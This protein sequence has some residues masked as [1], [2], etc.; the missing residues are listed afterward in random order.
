MGRL[1]GHKKYDDIL[2]EIEA[3][4]GWVELEDE[5]LEAA[6]VDEELDTSKADEETGDEADFLE[7][8]FVEAEQSEDV[9]AVEEAAEPEDPL[10]SMVVDLLEEDARE[11]Q[12][13]SDGA[14]RVIPVAEVKAERARAPWYESIM[15]DEEDEED[16]SNDSSYED[17]MCGGEAGYGYLCG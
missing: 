16:W 6:V 2:E 5:E 14:T 12:E 8:D 11:E 13:A 1:F 9:E 3:Q 10:Y 15:Y 7:A 17:Y 4:G